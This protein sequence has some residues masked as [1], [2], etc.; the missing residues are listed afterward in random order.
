MISN[1]KDGNK[2]WMFYYYTLNKLLQNNVEKVNQFIKNI[3]KAFLENFEQ[4]VDLLHI[5]N[6]SV[7]LL[8]VII[9]V[10]YLELIFK[11]PN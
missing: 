11:T 10:I 9:I 7:E 1:K 3:I 5:L 4:D 6:N 8:I 2:M